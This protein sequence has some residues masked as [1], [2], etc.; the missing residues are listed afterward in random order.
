[1]EQNI[2]EIFP[3]LNEIISLTLYFGAKFMLSFSC[4][5]VNC[6]VY[7][8]GEIKFILKQK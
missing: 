1:M 7:R 4:E 3:K 6:Q 2:K 5:R 8:T